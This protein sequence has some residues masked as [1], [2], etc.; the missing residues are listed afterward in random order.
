MNRGFAPLVA[1]L[2][3]VSLIG[4]AVVSGADGGVSNDG[5]C[6]FPATLTDGTGTEVTVEEEPESVVTLNPSA[7][8]T[9]WEI[10]AREKVT[11]VT[12]HA[13]NLEGAN[14]RLNITQGG[15]TINPEVVVDHDPDLV[16]APGSKVVSKELVDVLRESGL[17]VY[18]FPS[19]ESID[20][21]R[22]RTR[23]IGQLV[24]EC[25]G[26]EETVEWMNEEIEIAERAAEDQE[27]PEVLYVFFGFT[28]G[29][30]THIH[31]IIEAGGA[32]NIAGEVGISEYAAVNEETVVE[33]DPDWIVLNSDS[34]E[35]PDSV[36][37]EE[38]TA[39]QE[40]QIIVLDINH[41]NRPAPRIVHAISELA[42][43]FHPEAYEEAV[44]QAAETP[45]ETET[46]TP[47]P[48]PD[49]QPGFGVT[50][51]VGAFLALTLLFVRR[52]DGST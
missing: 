17:T 28:A 47:P 52:I 39:V 23:T 26:A 31:E 33:E 27:R 22:D 43:A 4:P 21:V 42:Q 44:T 35:V 3:A 36:A 30:D 18:Y 19:A 38:T 25:D 48:A 24:G 7:A 10:G 32:T 45:T 41:L 11:G 2:I 13:S 14:E 9:M 1:V 50:L 16:L 51:A 37:Y 34:P 20:D 5:G 40:D 6:S 8:Q 12:K 49:D 29:E 46:E 15:E